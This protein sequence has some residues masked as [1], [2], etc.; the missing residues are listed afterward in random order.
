MT[1]A[2]LLQLTVVQTYC[3][4]LDPKYVL[5]VG[6]P[7]KYDD[8]LLYLEMISYK[9]RGAPIQSI[10][11]KKDPALGW[12]GGVKGV[13]LLPRLN[14]ELTRTV[15]LSNISCL[16]TLRFHSYSRRLPALDGV[17]ST[18]P[19]SQCV[20]TKGHGNNSYCVRLGSE[21]IVQ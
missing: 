18:G 8:F 14:R 20:Y 11:Q 3:H 13:L 6:L 12:V 1:R 2:F 17:Q 10:Q 9:R 19:N 16:A 21:T 5:H 4:E 7:V 15:G